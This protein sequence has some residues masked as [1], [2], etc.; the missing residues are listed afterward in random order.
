MGEIK[1]YNKCKQMIEE[2]NRNF[3]KKVNE[4]KLKK[5]LKICDMIDD[6]IDR[7]S[8]L[9]IISKVSAK[10]NEITFTINLSDITIQDLDDKFP[11]LLGYAKKVTMRGITAD[12]GER[13]DMD[14]ESVELNVTFDGVWD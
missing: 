5:F 6:T 11:A 14:M 10:K 2:E 8:A 1:V 4:E 3:G 9:R 13:L 12:E 7:G